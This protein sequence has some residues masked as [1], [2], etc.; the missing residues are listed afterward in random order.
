MFDLRA[1]SLVVYDELNRPQFYTTTLGLFA[2]IAVGISALSIYA[3]V[4][5]IVSR[6]LREIAIRIALGATRGRIAFL[7][8]VRLALIVGA[9]MTVGL[10]VVVLGGQLA[11]A[12][13]FGVAQAGPGICLAAAFALCVTAAVASWAPLYRALTISPATAL[14][15]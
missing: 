5:A 14:R 8:L 2:A 7:V 13:Y 6:R 9:G 3:S 12:K 15:S 1:L 10:A 11:K 4:S